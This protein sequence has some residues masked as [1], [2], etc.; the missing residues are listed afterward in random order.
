MQNKLIQA[1]KTFNTQQLEALLDDKK[2]Y[3]DV[4]KDLFLKTLN[5]KFQFLKNHGIVQFD[6][7]HPG[8][9]QKCNKGCEGLTFFS[10]QGFY[11]DLFIEMEQNTSTLR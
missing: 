1:I 4:P 10:N 6:E 2:A 8:I 3:M 11:L 9:C 7:V 5:K